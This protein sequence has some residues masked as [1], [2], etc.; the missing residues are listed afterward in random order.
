MS[1]AMLFRPLGLAGMV[2]LITAFYYASHI[3]RRP[4]IFGYSLAATVLSTVGIVVAGL[5]GA[6]F[7]S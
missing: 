7:L 5:A 3:Y 6:A 1:V 2:L 4:S